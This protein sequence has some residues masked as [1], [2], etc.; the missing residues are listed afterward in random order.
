ERREE[1]E[2]EELEKCTICTVGC[3][4]PKLITATNLPYLERIGISVDNDGTFRSSKCNNEEVENGRCKS[5]R[6]KKKNLRQKH[7]VELMKPAPQEEPVESGDSISVPHLK[8][9]ARD[10]IEF[11]KDQGKEDEIPNDSILKDVATFE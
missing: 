6:N 10:R 9:Q 4:H 11:L 2:K 5:C 1:K 8:A 7:W 3:D